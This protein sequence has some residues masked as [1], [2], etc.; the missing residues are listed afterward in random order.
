MNSLITIEW[1]VR[2]ITIEDRYEIKLEATFETNVP[3]AVVMFHPLSVQLPVMEQGD[4]FQ[5]ELTLTNHGLIRA[6]NVRQ[7]L[8]SS[9]DLVSFEFLRAVPE[10]LEAGEVFTLPY[11]VRALRDFNPEADAMATGGGSGSFNTQ[12]RVN[13]QS[14]R[15]EEHTSE[16]Q[17]R[18]QLVC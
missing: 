16:L 10:A 3:V 8:P 1:S 17:S 15:S 6:T 13:Y 5:G 18:G 14:E 12:T 11:R 4:V 7:T 2:E 9:N